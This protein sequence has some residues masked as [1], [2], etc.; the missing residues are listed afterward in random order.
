[1]DTRGI[2]KIFIPAI[3]IT[4]LVCGGIHLYTQRDV[5]RFIESL[6]EPPPVSQPATEDRTTETP[7]FSR[8]APWEKRR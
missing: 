6:G 3:T 7:R 4:V 1:M 8:A 2:L 5:N